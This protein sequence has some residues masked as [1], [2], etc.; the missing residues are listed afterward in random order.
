MQISQGNIKYLL[1]T[2]KFWYFC[3]FITLNLFS[4]NMSLC[5]VN[6]NFQVT[7]KYYVLFKICQYAMY[8]RYKIRCVN[9]FLLQ[10]GVQTIIHLIQWLSRTQYQQQ[11]DFR[12]VFFNVIYRFVNSTLHLFK[13]VHICRVSNY[14]ILIFQYSWEVLKLWLFLIGILKLRLC[15]FLFF[16]LKKELLKLQFKSLVK[17]FKTILFP[18]QYTLQ[19]QE[20]DKTLIIRKKFLHPMN[21]KF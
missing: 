11:F 10:L 18:E 20:I 15:K 5:V 9:L 17:F 19:Q 13:K 1:V 14:N 8:T 2:L 7:N 4:N 16:D 12:K 6:K 3:I 21:S